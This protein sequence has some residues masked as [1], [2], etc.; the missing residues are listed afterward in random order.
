M[1]RI[2]CATIRFAANV[3]IGSMLALIAQPTALADT[4]LYGGLGGHG[5]TS[6]P[7]ASTNDG[8]LVIVSQI[9]GSTT[10]VGHPA[11]V[12]RIAGLAFGLDGALF[13]ATQGAGGFPPPPGPTA[14]SNLIRIN[15]DTGALISSVP[16]VDG[17]TPLS[18]GDLR[19]A[20]DNGCLVCHRRTGW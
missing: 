14:T 9:D 7:Q 18:I 16:I 20:P 13:G 8:A 1:K 6:G 17:A 10:L 15:P 19:R 11:G 3:V 4:V 2:A 5:I 12:A